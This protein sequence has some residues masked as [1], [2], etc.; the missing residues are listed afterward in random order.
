MDGEFFGGVSRLSVNII[1]GPGPSCVLAVVLGWG[2]EKNLAAEEWQ[3]DL[4][5]KTLEVLR[6]FV[7]I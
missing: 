2:R 5:R 4:G 1:E 3:T 6:G 7:S